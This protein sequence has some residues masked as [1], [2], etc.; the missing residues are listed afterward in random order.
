MIK[1]AVLVCHSQ[2]NSDEFEKRGWMDPRYDKI[3]TCSWSNRPIGQVKNRF[4]NNRCHCGRSGLNCTYLCSCCNSDDPCEKCMWRYWYTK[5]WVR[6]PW[7]WGVERLESRNLLKNTTFNLFMWKDINVSTLCIKS[8]LP[9]T[10]PLRGVTI[11]Y[12]FRHPRIS[13]LIVVYSKIPINGH[14]SVV[15]LFSLVLRH[16]STKLFF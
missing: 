13:K 10:W 1:C 7:Q 15:L 2:M 14:F 9:V 3:S 4:V 6:G 16:G 12:L 8:L 5:N 11:N